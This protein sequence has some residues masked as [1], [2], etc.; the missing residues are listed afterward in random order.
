MRPNKLA[1]SSS[2][3]SVTIIIITQWVSGGCGQRAL[4]RVCSVVTGRRFS[5]ALV[6]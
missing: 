5:I 2:H 4:P 6:L 3:L 1:L